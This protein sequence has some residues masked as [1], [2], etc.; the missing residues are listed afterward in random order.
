ME[1]KK[2][3]EEPKLEDIIAELKVMGSQLKEVFKTTVES[4][5]TRRLREQVA[6]GFD[7][8]TDAFDK[9]IKDA[10]SGQL[11]KDIKKGLR[12]SIR[13]INEKL[14]QYSEARKEEEEK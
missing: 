12:D 14:K 8:L 1:E 11:E 5:K 7:T 9:F 3:N 6:D 10:K 2:T 4:E 13:T